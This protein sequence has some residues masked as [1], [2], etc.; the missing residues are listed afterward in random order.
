MKSFGNVAENATQQADSLQQTSAALSE[1]LSMVTRTLENVT[2]SRSISNAIVKETENGSTSM[3]KMSKAMEKIEETNVSLEEMRKIIGQIYSKTSI[4]NN[5]VSK[6]ELLSL[7]AS[8]EAA[9]AGESG[10]GFAVVAEEVG[11]LAKISGNAANEIETLIQESIKKIETII[12]VTKLRVTEGVKTNKDS[13]H[14]FKDIAEKINEMK[15]R[16]DS[17]GEA[18]SEQKI[19]IERTTEAT[20]K[21]ST[22]TQTNTASANDAL[23]AAKSVENDSE[24]THQNMDDI[25]DLVYGKVAS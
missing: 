5:I 16:S 10:K 24:K 19:G 25:K 20:N 17:I 14:I 23:K 8:I 3:E 12:E 22:I 2:E 21:L 15:H 18:M 1:I 13:F 4:I 7:N 9:R 11:N 6:T